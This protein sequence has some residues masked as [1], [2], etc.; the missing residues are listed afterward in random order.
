MTDTTATSIAPQPSASLPSAQ[1]TAFTVILA[2]SFCHGINDIMQSLL[3]AIYPLLKENYGLDFWQI[4]LLTFTFQVTASLL[5]PVIGMIT[6]KRPMP[7][8]LPY[9][10]ASS[11]I[12]L[13]VLAYAGHY[14]LLLVGAS[15]IGIGSAIFHP[16]SSR[17]ARFASGGRFGLA[18]SLFQVGGNFGQS[19]GPLLA[20]FIV[21]PFGQTSISW[22]AV[23]SLIGIIVLSRVGGWYSRM[24]AAQ[25]NRKAA[26]FVS[27]FPRKKV[28]GALIVLTLL[29][30]TK[31]A[32]IASL[33]SYYTF[34]SIHKFGVS[35]Q[36]SQ[37]MLFLF[38]GA[39]ALG[40]LLG[41][42]FGD[43]YGQ[44]AM[45]W[46]SIVGVLPFTLALPYANF[47]W[48]MV[49]TVLIGL[50]LSS[51][52][53]NIVVFAQELVPGRV[54]TIA[55]IFFGFAFGMGGIA[56]AVLGVV[57]DMKGIDFVFQICSYLPLLGLL[58]VFLPNMKEARKAQAAA[59]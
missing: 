13:I 31:N 7:Y 45:I 49:L 20:A 21:V 40:I 51:A 30:L 18:Q 14:A 6:D 16:E 12:G 46:F 56:A 41:G 1:A 58:T 34:Y 11:L 9:G 59:R 37:V 44:K 33:S 43:R 50:I 8:S 54:G 35:V 17:I 15:L 42:P 53:S 24:R 10:M 2:V 36:M 47:E 29:V 27:P 39:S 28:M 4:G 55:G 22:F 32:Y 38:L 26:S 3:P 23:G 57:A 5:Q 48:T 19:M 52:F 25:G